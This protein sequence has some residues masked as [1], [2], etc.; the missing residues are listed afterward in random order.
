VASDYPIG[1]IAAQSIGEPGTQLS[2]DSKHRAGAVTAGDDVTQ[3]LTRV[4]ELL[5]V[6]TPKGQA[7]L[8]DI[9]GTVS[10][11]EE[12]DHYIIQI[13]AKEQK[14]LKLPLA[15]RTAHVNDGDEIA[16]G[17][18]VASQEDGSEP[19]I[20]NM[21]GKVKV[22]ETSVT[23][24]PTSKSVVRYEIPGYKQLTV[25]DGDEVVAGQ[26]ARAN[27]PAGRR[28]NSAL[29]HQRNPLHLCISGSKHCRQ[30]P[31]S[32]CSTDV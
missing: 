26:P 23:I 9:T 10:S 30:A 11:W 29:H 16:I 8:T 4:E 1:V 24:T 5:E 21:A 17:D 13:T 15:G 19:L 2:L 18:V 20:T 28:G 27:A 25:Q 7:Y 6:R 32:Y 14:A 12:G 31:R 3:G 22:N